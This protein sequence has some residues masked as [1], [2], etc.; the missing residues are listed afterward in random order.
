MILMSWPAVSWPSRNDE[1]DQEDR[2][3]DEVVGHAVAD[4][5]AEHADAQPS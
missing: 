3:E 4:R 2:E 1:R 5:L